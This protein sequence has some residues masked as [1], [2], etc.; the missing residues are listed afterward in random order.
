MI[1]RFIAR[2]LILLIPVV[3]GVTLLVFF[4]VHTAPGDPIKLKLGDRYQAEQAEYYRQKY[5]LDKPVPVQ[6]VLWLGHVLRGD[7]GRSIFT[8]EPVLRMITD[9]APT[10]ITLAVGTMFVALVISI[11]LGILAATHKDSWFDNVSRVLSMLGMSLPV[12]WLGLILII[13]FALWI[14]IFPPGGSVRE[15]GLKAIVLPSITLGVAFAA[16]ITRMMRST[17][18]EV[19]GE[20]YVR[21]ARAKGLSERSVQY[22]HAFRNAAIPV[23]TVVGLQFGTILG[24]AVL[25]E[26]IFSLPGL[27]RLLVDSVTRRDF[28]VIQGG[29]LFIS[30]IF[31]LSNL[32]V[33]VLYVIIDPRITY[34]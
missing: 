4:V 30:L 27:G 11:P 22:R 19:F 29:V 24:G 6:Y 33:D 1:M 34:K 21:T 28:P 32:A 3:F 15:Y 12:F 20:D 18:I 10:T 9:R 13:V 26:T 8:N 17:M 2:R 23:L 31:V 5:G 25:T 14:P 16:L 7:L